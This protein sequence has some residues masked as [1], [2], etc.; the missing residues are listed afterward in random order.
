MTYGSMGRATAMYK[1]TSALGAVEGA[2]PH[3]LT[4][5]LYDGVI[6][7]L[8]RAKSAIQHKDVPAKGEALSKAQ[9]IISELRL[10][11]DHK[12]GGKLSTRLEALYEYCGRRLLEAQI[13]D[14]IAIVDQVIGLLTPLRDAWAQ[15]RP[16]YLAGQQKAAVGAR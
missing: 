5:M 3:Q 11:L 7:R 6:Q 15:I 12:A 2:D 4:A 8:N 13:K 14:D 9:A 10:T 16:N 1:G